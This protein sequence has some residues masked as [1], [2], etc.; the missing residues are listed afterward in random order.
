MANQRWLSHNQATLSHPVR[1]AFLNGAGV[2]AVFAGMSVIVEL[3]DSNLTRDSQVV[4]G[5]PSWTLF[6]HRGEFGGSF[7]T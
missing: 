6:P 2:S 1:C 4:V 7:G 5:L 3:L